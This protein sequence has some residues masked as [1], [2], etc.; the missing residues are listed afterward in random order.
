MANT[1]TTGECL[2]GSVKRNRYFYGKLMTVRDFSQEQLYFNSK[3][4]LINRLLLGSGIICGLGL[5]SGTGDL[6]PTQVEIEPGLAINAAGQE[7]TV[8]RNSR[9]D[10]GVLGITPPQTGTT[11]TVFLR[12]LYHEC[13]DEPMPSVNASP[14]DEVCE[15]NRINETFTVTWG[16]VSDDAT[17]PDTTPCE[18]WLNRQTRVS[19]LTE[20]FDFIVER[21]T[22]LWVREGEAFEVAVKLTA[23]SNKLAVSLAERVD[24]AESLIEPS[25]ASPDIM[26]QFPTPPVNLKQDEFIAYVYQVRA[27]SAGTSI[28]INTDSEAKNAND[29]PP[30]ESVIEVVTATEAQE[31]ESA[32]VQRDCCDGLSSDPNDWW[33][34]IA[35]IELGF[36]G[37]QVSSINRVDT[38]GPTR[39]KY[40]LE[41]A[42]E[43]LECI[44]SRVLDEAGSARPGHFFL[45]SKEFDT[46][47]PWPIGAA[48]SRGSAFTTVRGDHVHQLIL[49]EQSGLAFQEDG[50][51]LFIEGDVGGEAIN[52]LHT[53]KGIDPAEA[54]DLTT[55]GYVDRQIHD[56]IAGLDWQQSVLDKD[57]TDPAQSG[58]ASETAAPP[59]YLLF[60][61]ELSGDWTELKNHIVEWNGTDWDAYPPQPGMA[62]FVEDEQR[63]YLYTA[64]AWQAF[65]ASPEVTAG[66]GLQA[67]LA[68]ASINVVV[69]PGLSVDPDHVSLIFNEETPAA[70][71]SKKYAHPGTQD[72]VAR[73]DHSHP[74][75][76]E[77][78]GGLVFDREKLRVAGAISDAVQFRSTAEGQSPTAPAQ[79]ATKGYVDQQIEDKITG[80]DWQQSVITRS[81]V[82]PPTSK[83][84]LG[85]RY[86]IATDDPQGDWASHPQNIA[87]W[88]SAGWKFVEPNK[89][90]AVFVEDEN[91]A[92]IYTEKGWSQFLGSPQQVRA[93]LGLVLTPTPTSGTELSVG[94]G[95]GIGVD[96]DHVFVAFSSDSPKP[97]GAASPGAEKTA[98][99]SDHVHPAPDYATGTHT[100]VAVFSLREPLPTHM[101]S[102][103]IDPR[104]GVEVIWVRLGLQTAFKVENREAVNSTDTGGAKEGGGETNNTGGMEGASVTSS[105]TSQETITKTLIALGDVENSDLSEM[106]PIY[107]TAQ[108]ELGT[109]YPYSVPTTFRI[110]ARSATEKPLPASFSV[111]WYASRPARDLGVLEM[112]TYTYTPPSP[113]E[114]NM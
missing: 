88:T 110:I 87:T 1:G 70:V 11:K 81:L 101:T 64:G 47:K 9:V 94:A 66:D 84:S 52:F 107:L 83:P 95:E 50:Q 40:S 102:Q 5:K 74:L 54:R 12:L 22:P 96:A 17:E 80:L 69:G 89:G 51:S 39:L 85:S 113:N 93:G 92:Y 48:G 98:S 53:V 8:T 21:T 104:L 2:I 30:L 14:C 97:L 86:L 77:E 76:L 32:L 78:N 57:L 106:P 58:A 90:M 112:S 3:R 38:F 55:K 16:D 18:S 72:T 41:R 45:T 75:L 31:R 100:G 82:A 23:T 114:T 35:V 13:P 4:W 56:K 68:D 7:I 71:T 26:K 42:G 60:R 46:D 79:L 67:N 49:A 6:K 24:P 36:T 19:E 27:G 108:V 34:N 59:R 44:R 91:I 10:L 28:T 62:V 29:I 65:L 61:S 20:D 37:D 73:G 15:S 109:E 63:A 33:V 25:P 105:D 103:P 43:L 99:R 111:R